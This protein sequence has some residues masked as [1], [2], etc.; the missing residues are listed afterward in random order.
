MF[1]GEYPKGK[2]RYG[3]AADDEVVFKLDGLSTLL[4]AKGG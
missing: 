1:T 3:V 2:G 4:R